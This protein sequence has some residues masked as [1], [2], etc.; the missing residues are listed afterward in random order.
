M[1]KA[2]WLTYSFNVRFEGRN[3]CRLTDKMMMNNGNT[4]CLGGVVQAPVVGPK[5]AADLRSPVEEE[6]EGEVVIRLAIDPR[7]VPG[8]KARFVLF[9][10]DASYKQARTIEDDR[11]PGDRFVDLLFTELKTRS[12]Y[13]LRVESE[14]REPRA[15][16]ERVPFAWLSSLTR[17]VGEEVETDEPPSTRRRRGAEYVVIDEE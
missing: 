16:F 2:T 3:V 11:I 14:A 8:F 15:L 4:A 17:P 13:S 1:G 12:R 6:L 10:E 7:R 5:G 9:S